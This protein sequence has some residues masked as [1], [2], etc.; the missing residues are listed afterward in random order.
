MTIATNPL[1]IGCLGLWLGLLAITVDSA[2]ARELIE[3]PMPFPDGGVGDAETSEGH[4]LSANGRFVVFTSFAT[5]LIADDA[6]GASDVFVWDSQLNRVELVSRSNTG[7]QANGDSFDAVISADGQWVAF[8]STASNLTQDTNGAVE[9]VFLYSRTT[10]TIELVSRSTSGVQSQMASVRPDIN[11]N[12]RYVTFDSVG[13][14]V[15]GSDASHSQVFRR[16]NWTD[17]TELISQ[18]LL[19]VAANDMSID[20]QMSADGERIVFVSMASNLVSTATVGKESF[21]RDMTDGSLQLLSL[22]AAGEAG[23]GISYFPTISGDGRFVAFHTNASNLVSDDNPDA[24]DVVLRDVS[25]GQ[26]ELLSRSVNGVPADNFSIHPSLSYDGALAVFATNATT[27]VPGAAPEH[28]DILLADRGASTL[29]LLSQNPLGQPANG[30]SGAASISLDGSSVAFKSRASNLSANGTMFSDVLLDRLDSDTASDTAVV[31]AVLPSSRSVM[32][33]DSLTTFASVISTGIANNCQVQ[34]NDTASD[35][36]DMSYQ[37]TDPLTNSLVGVPGQPF[38]LL[39]GI[40]QTLLLTL[41]PTAATSAQELSFEFACAENSAPVIP[42]TNTLLVSAE[43]TQPA[44]VVAL[45]A[46]VENNGVV[47]LSLG[48]G[49]GFFTVASVNLGASASMN[50]R[51]VVLGVPLDG[52][53]ICQTDPLT[54]VCLSDAGSVVEVDIAAGE[55]PTFAVFVSHSTDIEFAPAQNRLIVQ[56][57]DSAGIVRGRTSVA[58]RSLN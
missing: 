17:R 50:V 22:N 2:N 3:P 45:S 6:N 5:N 49:T 27:L 21:L 40:P 29:N 25:S 13:E 35:A 58:I 56:F 39:P 42:A 34:L 24:T 23:N 1:S 31:A 33:G 54:S 7:T 10:S 44:D 16:D 14:L 48:G 43:S 15:G 46:T 51:P 32:L 11:A 30:D 8:T 9:D 4:A 47:S 20:A 41:T 55:T 28:F 12:G 53:S 37:A 19:G 26:L 18:N 38:L 57:E 52:F 36:A